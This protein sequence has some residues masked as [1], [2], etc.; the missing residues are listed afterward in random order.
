MET[1]WGA[2]WQ[3]MCMYVYVHV[4][5]PAHLTLFLNIRWNRPVSFKKTAAR[6]KI[7]DTITSTTYVA[8]P[9]F[10]EQCLSPTDE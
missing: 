6:G 7:T 8:S 10:I 1:H 5:L 9:L 2:T 3:S 4:L